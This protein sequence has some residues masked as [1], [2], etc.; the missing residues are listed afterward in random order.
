MARRS[1]P[2]QNAMTMLIASARL[3]HSNWMG[4]NN[5]PIPAMTARLVAIIFAHGTAKLALEASSLMCA[6]TS[7]AAR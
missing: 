7:K 1:F 5:L 6:V 3:T 2:I 4:N